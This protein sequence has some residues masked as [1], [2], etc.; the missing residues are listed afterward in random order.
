MTECISYHLIWIGIIIYHE[1]DIY[2][3]IEYDICQLSD[4]G[5]VGNYKKHLKKKKQ[6]TI[7][8]IVNNK[9]MSNLLLGFCEILH[10]FEEVEELSITWDKRNKDTTEL[11]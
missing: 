5:L 8:H 4:E 3:P 9:Y 1:A 6:H 11:T 7:Q 2:V 10:N